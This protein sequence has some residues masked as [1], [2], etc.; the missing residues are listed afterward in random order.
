MNNAML[1][2]VYCSVVV[3]VIM[4][5]LSLS[6]VFSWASKFHL[7]FDVCTS[8]LYYILNHKHQNVRKVQLL[9]AAHLGELHSRISYNI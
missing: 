2:G 5:S 1:R 3:E 7:S 4:H 9:C 8:A 6:F